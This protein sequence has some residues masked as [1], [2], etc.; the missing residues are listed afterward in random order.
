MCTIVVKHRHCVVWKLKFTGVVGFGGESVLAGGAAPLFRKHLKKRDHR[1]SNIN[2]ERFVGK[3]NCNSMVGSSVGQ[4][5]PFDRQL[6][7][8]STHS[9]Q[10]F[11]AS[12]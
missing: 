4:T 6:S 9:A 1:K 2:G 5:R 3:T 11:A 7:R 12:Q 8:L 10:S